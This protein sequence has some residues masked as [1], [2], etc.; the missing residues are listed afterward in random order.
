MRLGWIWSL[1]ALLADNARRLKR[2]GWPLIS[3]LLQLPYTKFERV[4]KTEEFQIPVGR[5]FDGG[6]P[7]GSDL[8]ESTYGGGGSG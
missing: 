6:G 2:G 5:E 8:P 7:P 1:A 4:V 3:Q